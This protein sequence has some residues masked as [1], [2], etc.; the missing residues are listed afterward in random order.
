MADFKFAK[1]TAA[2]LRKLGSKGNA[3]EIKVA[4]ID[5]LS[6][7]EAFRYIQKDLPNR[8]E[9]Y[10]KKM[11]EIISGGQNFITE[12]V[13]V[14]RGYHDTLL[15][16][17]NLQGLH[18]LT[19]ASPDMDELLLK[20]IT[21]T[22]K[23]STIGLSDLYIVTKRKSSTEVVGYPVNPV[24]PFPVSNTKIKLARL[25]VIPLTDSLYMGLS[26]RGGFYVREENLLIPLILEDAPDYVDALQKLSSPTYMKDA[27]KNIHSFNKFVHDTNEKM[28]GSTISPY[29]VMGKVKVESATPNS[30][31]T[32]GSGQAAQPSA[33]QNVK[34]QVTPTPS[35]NTPLSQAIPLGGTPGT[36]ATSST[37]IHSETINSFKDK[38]P[39]EQTTEI[40]GFHRGDQ[41]PFPS[42]SHNDSEWILAFTATKKAMLD[43]RFYFPQT[44]DRDIL[45]TAA[46]HGQ[47]PESVI[48]D[49]TMDR[50]ALID[51]ANMPLDKKRAYE[52]ALLNRFFKSNNLETANNLPEA[53]NI[54]TS[55]PTVYAEWLKL[56]AEPSKLYSIAPQIQDFR[57]GA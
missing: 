30:R 31:I 22:E 32:F 50:R 46:A 10:N 26:K 17:V 29:A 25:Q 33:Q 41:Q 2:R 53:Y 16:A 15:N 51:V 47:S 20:N 12:S 5:D 37:V 4:S 38:H 55:N 18:E 43:S 7:D 14:E 3:P 9:L 13:K 34:V 24:S 48:S 45:I 28:R 19:L 1:A 54:L 56:V 49:N 8:L 27:V 11:N 35:Q 44:F 39:N 40:L 52:V 57:V 6:Y 23:G 36:G 21:V 42:I